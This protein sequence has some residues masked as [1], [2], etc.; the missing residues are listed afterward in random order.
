MCKK[1]HSI[2]NRG[3]KGLG[4]KIGRTKER[5]RKQDGNEDGV[6]G[7]L[8]SEG[9]MCVKVVV[10]SLRGGWWKRS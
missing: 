5:R 6:W 9:K 1:H 3:A 8:S 10:E 2:V 7:S 4:D